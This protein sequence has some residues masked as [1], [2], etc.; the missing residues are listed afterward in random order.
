MFKGIRSKVSGLFVRRSELLKLECA[1][2]RMRADVSQ[3]ILTCYRGLHD[4]ERR[5]AD[6]RRKADEPKA[7]QKEGEE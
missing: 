1:I 6:K 3:D 2:E 4:L 5:K 7:E